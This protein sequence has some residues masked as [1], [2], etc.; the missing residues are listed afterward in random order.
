VFE[1]NVGDPKTLLP[2]VEKVRKEFGLD[3]LVM[4]GDPA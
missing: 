4:V 1:G 3:R 2:Q